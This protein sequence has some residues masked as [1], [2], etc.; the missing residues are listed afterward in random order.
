MLARRLGT[1]RI[2][3]GHS[4]GPA[5]TWWGKLV[6]G[7]ATRG[8]RVCVR[9]EPSAKLLGELGVPC[10]RGPDLAFVWSAATS[11]TRRDGGQSGMSVIGVTARQVGRAAKQQAFEDELV[12]AVNNLVRVAAAEGKATEVRLLPQVKGPRHDEDDR[13]VLRRI[14]RRI[15]GDTRLVE[16]SHDD[17]AAA[18]GAYSELEFLIATRLHSA[19]LASCAGI[20]FVVY[21]YIGGKARGAVADLGLPS[22]IVLSKL[23]GVTDTVVRG[24]KDRRRLAL[25]IDLGLPRIVTDLHG[26]ARRD[27]LSL[28]SRGLGGSLASQEYSVARETAND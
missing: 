23:D 19:I 27:L 24:W 10:S 21:E 11:R 3:W 4:I 13:I 1:P 18:I 16:L 28:A 9:D 6:L 15:E 20:P 8:A 25:A 26:L 17:V 22:W 14:A 12:A 7:I 5:D 2:L